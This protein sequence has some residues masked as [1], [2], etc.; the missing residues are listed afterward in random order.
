LEIRLDAARLGRGL[1]SAIDGEL[2]GER[3][4]K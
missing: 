3:G 2:R 1:G 4:A